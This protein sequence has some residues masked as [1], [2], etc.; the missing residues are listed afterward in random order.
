MLKRSKG[1]CERCG[2]KG[3]LEIDHFIPKEKGG[4]S[5]IDNANALCSRCNDKKCAKLPHI[6]LEEEFGQL[7]K[8]FEDRDMKHKVKDLCK[9]YAL[10]VDVEE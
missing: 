4:T 7:V 5:T 6:W 2:Y 10:S 9:T 1:R 3:K 8:Y